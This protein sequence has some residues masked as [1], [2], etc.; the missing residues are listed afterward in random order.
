[1]LTNLDDSFQL[2][3]AVVD[4]SKLPLPDKTFDTVIDTFGLCSFEE[5]EAALREMKRCCKPGGL[6]TDRIHVTISLIDV[7]TITLQGRC[8]C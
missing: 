8:C 2:T 1:M 6:L 5:P 7:F 4:A 3:L